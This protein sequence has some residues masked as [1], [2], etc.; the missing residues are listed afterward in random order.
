[1]LY[2]GLGDLPHF[3]PDLDG[4]TVSP[5]VKDWRSRLLAAGGVIFS[6]PEYAHGLP[7]V[8]KNALDWVVGSG[9]LVD[10]PVALFNASPRGTYAQASLSETLTTMTARV[11]PDASLTLQILTKPVDA[12]RIAADP[13][14]SAALRTAILSFA[15]AIESSMTVT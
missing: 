10:K 3:N 12:G 14:M 15:R 5:A 11:V 4:E 8:L 13:G 7:G 6:V 9:E 1:M 2:K